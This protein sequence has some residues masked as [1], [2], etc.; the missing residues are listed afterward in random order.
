MKSGDGVVGVVGGV[1]ACVRAILETIR[2]IN[3]A[4]VTMVV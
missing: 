2:I 3:R 4:Y 1:W